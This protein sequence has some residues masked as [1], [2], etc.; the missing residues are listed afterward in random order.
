MA[1]VLA[2]ASVAMIVLLAVA[3]AWLNTVNNSSWT[4]VWWS[5]VIGLP[6]VLV[7]F[8]VVQRQPR[9]PVGWIL[10]GVIGL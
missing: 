8:V 5:A 9:N 7:G 4:G 2:F 3:L 6:F 10:M 1:R